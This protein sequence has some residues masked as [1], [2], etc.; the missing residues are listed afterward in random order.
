MDQLLALWAQTN[1]FRFQY[2]VTPFS[3]YE[4]PLIAIAAYILMVII[5]PKIMNN[6]SKPIKMTTF[7]ILHNYFLCFLSIAMVGGQVAATYNLLSQGYEV[8][9]LL[10]D[11]KGLTLKGSFNFWTYVFYLSKFYEFIDTFLLIVNKKPLIFLHVYHHIITLVIVWCGLWGDVVLQWL[12]VV[13]N[14]GV[15]VIMYYYYAIVA[16][17][18]KDIWWKR[19]ITSIQ[20]VQFILDLILPQIFLYYKFYLGMSC[21]GS[22]YVFVF[23][24]LIIVSFLVLFVQFYKKTYN[25]K[26]EAKKT[27]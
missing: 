2:G 15:H 16:S 6:F 20:I 21:P 11:P 18:R 27:Q 19:Y 17:G 12:A 25:K 23:G 1:E 9:D 3:T 14:G 13:T 22:D 4:Y 7:T 26:P 24:E 10:C 5:G 8:S